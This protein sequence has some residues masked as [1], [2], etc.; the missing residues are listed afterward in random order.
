[1]ILPLAPAVLLLV[2]FLAGCTQ[3]P[4]YAQD[5]EA[6]TIS[7]WLDRDDAAFV[8]GEDYDALWTGAIAV[9]RRFGFETD[10]ADYRG[11]RIVTR[12]RDSGQFFE[13][14]RDELRT[15]G[16]VLE[17]SLTATRRRVHIDFERDGD[18]FT[19]TPRVVVE[20]LAL[21]ERRITD[22]TAFGGTLGTGRQRRRA[23]DEPSPDLGWF[24]IGRDPALERTLARGLTT[25][26]NADR[27]QARFQL[28]ADP[29]RD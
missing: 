26:A 16:D 24:P 12:P 17:S 28:A 2:T 22:A 15:A 25:R 11:G 13:P 18:A 6:A 3:R 27:G 14:W 4:D 9:L 19:A 20:R 29:S 10:L 8:R 7:F 23:I 1:V 21:G 5:R